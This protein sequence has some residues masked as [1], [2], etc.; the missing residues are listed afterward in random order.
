MLRTARMRILCILKVGILVG[1]LLMGESYAQ[2]SKEKTPLPHR[3]TP[4]PKIDGYGPYKFGM[5]I[6][7]AQEARPEAKRTEGNCGYNAIDAAYCL[8]ET[9]RLFGRDAKIEVLFRKNTKT[10]S[11]VIITF[12]RIKGK[13][14]ACG[15]ALEAI[16]TPLFQKWGTPT[17][18]EGNGVQ[19]FWESVYGG[20][21]M[22]FGTCFDDNHGFFVVSY[23]DTP[24]S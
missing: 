5:S 7:R 8:T 19:L 4:V 17:R 13:E 23:E 9:T 18:E 3:T 10:L 6:G 2:T 12:D 24:G 15:K 11:N 20:T 22:L 14:K 16:A 21:L 1:L